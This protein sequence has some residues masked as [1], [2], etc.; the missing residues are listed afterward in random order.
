MHF[1]TSLEEVYQG[2]LRRKCLELGFLCRRKQD[3][4]CIF[5]RGMCWARFKI[6]NWIAAE[7]ADQGKNG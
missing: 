1:M 4:K 6:L 2:I 5:L 3:P 7:S